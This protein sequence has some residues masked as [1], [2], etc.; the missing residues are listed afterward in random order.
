MCTN[1]DFVENMY[2]DFFGM[3]KQ[4]KIEKIFSQYILEEKQ[5]P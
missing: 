5:H 4:V 3:L 1:S 2:R